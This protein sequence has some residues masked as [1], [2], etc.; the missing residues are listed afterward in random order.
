MKS[1]IYFKHF[2]SFLLIFC[3]AV[4]SLSAQT[5]DF[6]APRENKLLNGARLLVWKDSKTDK[7]AVKIRIHSGSAFDPQGKE[8]VMQL[9]SDILFPT[10]STKDFFIEDLNGSFEVVTNYDYIQINVSGNADKF[11][12]MLETLAP[13]VTNPQINKE[14]TEKVRTA[15]LARV[16]ELEKNPAFVADRAVSRRLF[17]NFPYGRSPFGTPES[18]AKIDFADILLANQKFLTADNA[19]IAIRGNVDPDFAFRAA[20][21]LFGGWLK[22][23]KKIPSTFAQPEAPP[24]GLQVIDSTADKTSEIRFAIRGLARNDKDYFASVILEKVLLNRINKLGGKN[25]FVRQNAN[26]LPGFFIFGISEWDAGTVKP[27]EMAGYRNNF[28]KAAVTAEE[29]QTGKNDLNTKYKQPDLPDYWLD[30][31]TYNFASVKNDWANFQSVSQTD[32][33][34]VLEK[35]QKAAVA[36]VLVVSGEKS[37]NNSATSNE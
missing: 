10:E 32:V 18:L 20:K 35:L 31:Q 4:L 17:G 19:T 13:A 9:L 22:S 14:T 27:E 36:S 23:D 24:A 7:V 5:Q 21:R 34:R 37:N 29:F 3:A 2:V 1:N 12:T 15:L 25:A 11:L 33:Q 28:L 6:P 8:G 26:I 30:S 16:S